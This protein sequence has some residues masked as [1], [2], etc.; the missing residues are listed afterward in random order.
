MEN[1]TNQTGRENEILRTAFLQTPV[2]ID[3][4]RMKRTFMDTAKK[5]FVRHLGF[6]RER[7]SWLTPPRLVLTGAAFY[8]AIVL[9]YLGFIVSSSPIQ[10]IRGIDPPSIKT[11]FQAA[12]GNPVSYKNGNELQLQDGTTITCLQDS[13]FGVVYSLQERIIE[14]QRGTIEI[15]AAH[16]PA[17]PM[18]VIIGES[19][20]RVTGTRFVVST[21]KP[22]SVND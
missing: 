15:A 14:L 5:R 4:E 7:I 20:I 17:I 6:R 8:G 10:R 9:A 12:V 21:E 16:N 1:K 13:F 22:F 11:T 19:R 3:R 18:I 2:P